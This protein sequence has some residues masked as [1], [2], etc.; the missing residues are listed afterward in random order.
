MKFEDKHVKRLETLDSVS[1]QLVN[2]EVEQLD[3]LSCCRSVW[4]LHA[5][6]E[7]SWTTF[8]DLW[9]VYFAP[10]V[11]W[12]NTRSPWHE[13]NYSLHSDV[14]VPD[15]PVCNEVRWWKHCLTCCKYNI[16]NLLIYII[17]YHRLKWSD[18]VVQVFDCVHSPSQQ[19][20]VQSR[21]LGPQMI[22]NVLTE[23]LRQ[24]SGR[25]Q[26]QTNSPNLVSQHMAHLFL[27]PYIIVRWVSRLHDY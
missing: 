7:G 2:G 10:T 1:L 16:T 12:M 14:S 15:V 27:T 25:K 22:D 17:V 11:A 26:H 23:R 3:R 5:D 13:C 6:C 4:L 19:V 21:L 9:L 8:Q 24:V 18:C 20:A